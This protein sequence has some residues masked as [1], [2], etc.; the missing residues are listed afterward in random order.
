[1]QIKEKSF[2][3]YY[4][5]DSIVSIIRSIYQQACWPSE[6]GQAIQGP[7]IPLIRRIGH[8]IEWFMGILKKKIG[9]KKNTSVVKLW[10]T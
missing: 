1:M 5:K 6:K 3:N 7:N 4:L 2:I 10:G 8:A 9:E